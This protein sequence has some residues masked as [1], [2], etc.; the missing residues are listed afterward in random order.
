M[1]IHHDKGK[2]FNS[3]LF[4]HLHKLSGISSSNTTPYHPMGDGQAERLNRTVKNMLKSI[5]ENEKRKWRDHLPKL[6][7]AYNS[8]VHKSTGFS[9]FFLLFGRES[10]LPVDGYFPCPHV[11]GSEDDATS[12]S[13]F[14]KTWRDRMTEA[15]QIAN[16]NVAK[17]DEYNKRKYD[18]KAFLGADI[19]VGDRVVVKR[20]TREEGTTGKLDTYWEATLFHVVEKKPDLPVYVIKNHANGKVRVLHRNLLKVVN[21]LVPV[22]VSVVPPEKEVA[23][24]SNLSAAAPAFVPAGTKEAPKRR[25]RRNKRPV[26][27]DSPSTSEDEE[28]VVVHQHS[29]MD[30]PAI[31]DEITENVVAT[32]DEEG[33]NMMRLIEV[34]PDEQSEGSVSESADEASEAE[35]LDDVVDIS[36]ESVFD[37]DSELEG[38]EGIEPLPTSAESSPTVESPP[39]RV[40][41][42]PRNRCSRIRRKKKDLTYDQLG[43]PTYR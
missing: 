18:E 29:Q 37:D 19:A 39:P 28:V 38:G 40:R 3:N 11:P 25:S 22:D 42:S 43:K 21:E 10:R 30:T 34:V 13:E 14:A 27:Q 33:G 6:M 36:E 41:L 16:K 9:P 32:P 4:K 23:P 1:R 15:F 35:I 2:E 12:Y 26:I 31:L 7:F 20:L 8:T 17:S 24:T 5:P